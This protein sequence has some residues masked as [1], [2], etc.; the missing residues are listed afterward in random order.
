MA[1]LSL[2]TKIELNSH[3]L[4]AI[5]RSN[6][7]S[8]I[9]VHGHQRAFFPESHWEGIADAVIANRSICELLFAGVPFSVHWKRIKSVCKI[10]EEIP[11]P[12][13]LLTR[14]NES[15]LAWPALNSLT[16][17]S[18]KFSSSHLQALLETLRTNQ[19]I[20]TLKFMAYE[21]ADLRPV[22]QILQ[23]NDTITSLILD[24][25]TLTAKEGFVEFLKQNR[26]VTKFKF[27]AY[28]FD[29]SYWTLIEEVL[30]VNKTAYIIQFNKRMTQNPEKYNTTI[31][32]S[33]AE[34]LSRNRKR[35]QAINDS[36]YNT[37]ILVWMMA[38]RP[39]AYFGVFPREIWNE[40]FR[41]V[42][43]PGVKSTFSIELMYMLNKKT[44]K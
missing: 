20:T 23:Q 9:Y 5:K 11:N 14:V 18:C 33:V 1:G 34:A 4:D 29:E 40:I 32:E 17:A 39:R 41:H 13:A 7:L 24:S 25:T 12:I 26:S 30:E 35:V 31:P 42:R 3:L 19:I 38:K 10:L 8:V 36:V 22:F 28:N 16:F 37:K 44:I 27:K 21:D 15:Q 6:N 2:G 43:I